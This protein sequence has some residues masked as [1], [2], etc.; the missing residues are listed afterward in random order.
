MYKI[1][2]IILIFLFIYNSFHY[3]NKNINKENFINKNDLDVNEPHFNITQPFFKKIL[4]NHNLNVEFKNNKYIITKND[5]IL[6]SYQTKYF[7]NE[8]AYKIPKNKYLTYKIYK[9]NNLPVPEFILITHK[10]KNKILKDTI[11]GFPCV[12]KPIDGTG[13]KDVN[14]F[15]NNKENFKKILNL[16]IKKYNKVLYEQ[17]I[18][19]KNYR[20]L[21]F[22][23]KII[24]VI[25]RQNPFIIGN[26]FN[27]I[28]QL[29]EKKNKK[30]KKN[31]IFETKMNKADWG[32]IKKQGYNKN[33]ILPKNTKVIITNTVNVHNGAIPVRI[34]LDSIP[35]INKKMF[36]KATSLMKLIC[37]GIDFI[38]KDITVPYNINNSKIIE[39]NSIPYTYMHNILDLNNSDNSCFI[40][41]KIANIILDNK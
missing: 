17:H 12:L 5:K 9:K 23:N 39:I 33:D 27:T 35:E 22:E 7:N 8:G 19:G 11:L 1:F 29:I 4:K 40:F 3:I 21:I 32:Y 24:D 14:S 20:I 30:N 31:K 41:D 18:I 2:Y 38:S 13:G 16:L 15:I 6:R 36:L 26:G 25:E 10:N 37:S 28:V 34:N